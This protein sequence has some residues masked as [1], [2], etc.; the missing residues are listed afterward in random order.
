MEAL[1]LFT[2]AETVQKDMMICAKCERK[3]VGKNLL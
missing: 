2:F 3:L 1:E